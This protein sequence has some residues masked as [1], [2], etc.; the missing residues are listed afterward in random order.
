MMLSAARRVV[1]LLATFTC[2]VCVMS[3]AIL[4][5]HTA[6]NDRA[7]DELRDAVSSPESADQNDTGQDG[8]SPDMDNL[9]SMDIAAWL[10][11]GGTDISY[12]VVQPD[13]DL[14][15][16]WYLT[17]NVW[18]DWDPLGCPYLD[19]RSGVEGKHLLVFGHHMQG[20]NQMFSELSSAYEQDS[21]D[22]IRMASWATPQGDVTE[23][24]PLLAMN[25]DASYVSIQR[26][27]FTDSDDLH[28]WL[29]ELIGSATA[30]SPNA[31]A[32]TE[33]ATR[34]LTLVTCSEA[35]A[36]G[37]TRTLIVFAQVDALSEE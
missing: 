2:L 24:T 31:I 3:A 20:T 18:G 13:D 1:R 5:A 12:P 26:F 25:V 35:Q 32:F 28:A 8:A 4:L 30:V 9:R 11:V 23:F 16:D 36:G 6:V 10:T 29:K 22:T 19:R 27:E 14:P 15:R 21:F 34:V 7:Y 17:H 33:H 37:R